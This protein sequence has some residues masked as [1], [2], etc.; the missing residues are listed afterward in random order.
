MTSSTENH[1]QIQN[2]ILAALPAKE[3]ERLLPHLEQI[4]LNLGEVLSQPDEPLQYVYFPNRGTISLVVVLEDG[5]EVEAGVIGNEGMLGLAV[6]AGTNSMPLQAIVQIPDG[7]MRLKVGVFREE[8]NRHEQLHRLLLNY[9]QALFVQAAQTAACNRLHRLDA[10]LARW[11]LMC[12]D[13]SKADDLQLTHEFLAVMLGVRRAGVSMAASKF[14]ED[15]LIKYTRGH[16]RILDRKGLEAASCECY[17][18]VRDEFDRL[19]PA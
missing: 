4:A 17:G 12:Q 14:Q 7:G 18:V 10:R 16:L 5:S 6:V 1:S 8:F 15:G 9:S 13:R 2:R 19:L 11:L 3:Y